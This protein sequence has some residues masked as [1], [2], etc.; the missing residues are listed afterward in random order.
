VARADERQRLAR[1]CH[2]L[3]EQLDLPAARLGAGKARLDHARV[4]HHQR[5]ARAHERGQVG[6]GEVLE[7]AARRVQAQQAARGA[8][9]GRAL[10]DQL[11]GQR[12]VEL[13]EAHFAAL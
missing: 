5:V 9:G 12:I 11:L 7:P 8:P 10:G 1:A 2:A 3:D 13:R 4:V 6:E